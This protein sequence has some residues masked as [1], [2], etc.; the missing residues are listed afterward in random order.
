MHRPR[1]E[2]LNI[3]QVINEASKLTKT[4][5]LKKTNS[6]L[7]YLDIHDDYIH[8]LYPIIESQLVKKPEYFGSDMCGAHISV[9]YPEEHVSPH[10]D[11]LYQMHTF[12]L[13][14]AFTAEIGSKRYYGLLV[15]APSLELLR[16]KYGLSELLVFKNYLIDFHITIGVQVIK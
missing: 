14:D 16:K 1:I 2:I 15:T 7:I 11:D 6:N 4:G 13:K 12:E 9:I 8:R 3:P 5:K 10:R